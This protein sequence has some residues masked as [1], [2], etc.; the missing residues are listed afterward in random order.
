MRIESDIGGTFTDLV[1]LDEASGEVGVAKV[2]TT[3]RD[4]AEGVIE[5]LRRGKVDAPG[6]RFF[7]HGSTIFMNVPV[8]GPAVIEEPAS[9][10]VIFPGQK[11]V[12]DKYGF[13]HIEKAG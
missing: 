6:A 3:P 5:T 8:N 2:S 4:F 11:V 10:A 9:T 12:R 7:V 13:M 1:V